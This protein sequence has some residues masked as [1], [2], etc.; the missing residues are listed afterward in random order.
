MQFPLCHHKTTTR[1][2]S[3]DA[4][5]PATRR[6][7]LLVDG[8]ARAMILPFG[9]FLVHR[10]V[11]QSDV[12]TRETWPG[13]A[14]YFAFAVSVYLVGRWLGTV[15][16][17]SS[18]AKLTRRVARLG[19]AALALHVVTYGAGLASVTWLIAIRGLSAMLAGMLCGI[20][21]H[22]A[23]PEDA[24]LQSD[25][26]SFS[27]ESSMQ[28]VRRRQGYVDI[29]S[30]TAKIY[31]VG[32]A[33]SILS[34]GLL[35]RK[36]T[37]DSTFQ[38]LTGAYQYSWSPLFL[39]AVAVVVEVALRFL[40][41]RA[42]RSIP[43]TPRTRMRT[44][45]RNEKL[46][47]VSEDDDEDETDPLALS[48]SHS[49]RRRGSYSTPGRTRMES[50]TSIDD[51]H[52]C[53]S[54]FSDMDDA[55][56]S[57]RSL[58]PPMD[59]D[60]VAL[61]QDGKCVYPN[62]QPAMVPAGDSIARIPANYAAFYNGNEDKARRAWENTQQWRLEKRVW[63]IHRTP[64]T[65]F[66]K[67]KEAYPH[68]VHGFSKAGYP[69][70]Y[71][72]PGKMN[73]KE[74]FRSGC[75]ISDMVHH[76]T[77]F[78]EFIAHRIC[79]R[80]DVR[81]AL[82]PNAPPHSSSSWGIMVVMD[83]AGAGISSLSGDVLKYLK[84]AGDINSGH[85]PQNMKRAFVINSPFWLA[86]A[87]SGIKGILPESV[88][89]DLLS[90]TKY[91]E[92][93]REYIDEDQIPP[94]YGG[95]SPYPLGQ[96]PFET[97]LREL[98]AEAEKFAEE[99]DEDPELAA[100]HSPP[101]LEFGSID[102]MRVVSPLPGSSSRLRTPDPKPLR[103]RIGSVERVGAAQRNRARTA[104]EEIS[105]KRKVV[106]G[107]EVDI[108]T[109]VSAIHFGWS[110]VQGAIELALPLWLVS[111][112]EFGGLGYSPSRSGVSF[113]C[114]L[115]VLMWVMRTRNSKLVAQIPSKEPLRALRI[116]AGSE[117]V[118]FSLLSTIVT[119]TKPEDRQTSVMIMTAVI[120]GLSCLA[121]AS[122]LGRSASKILHRIAAD[123]IARSPQSQSWYAKYYKSNRLLQDCESGQ[124]TTYLAIA[125]EA[126]GILCV[127]PF[128]SW[129][130]S[131]GREAPFD[132][133]AFLSVVSLF[134]FVLYVCS[135]SLYLN[136]AGEFAPN[137]KDS[138]ANM[139]LRRILS[140][141]G[142]IVAVSAGDMASLLEETNWRTSLRHRSAS[143][144]SYMMAASME[145]GMDKGR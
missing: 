100:I 101:I 11:Y 51:F 75:D 99:E 71:E 79:T 114:A 86:G 23:L 72:Q 85:Y 126:T 133:S 106:F 142:E 136:T 67:I 38:A 132:G 26:A 129:S 108:F 3:S 1:T 139:G 69:I 104:S 15:L 32:F 9:P 98:V 134:S 121:L 45:S 143:S 57:G 87:W 80:T 27:L 53:R 144:N 33:L 18:T 43:P 93:L 95:T 115:L 60:E 116:G 55:F 81:A 62:G 30:G 91:P 107:V 25:P 7:A 42:A 113:F 77:F 119:A 37:K 46:P 21:A 39:I 59:A 122:M 36:V 58:S 131:S 145:E 102:E 29:S 78:T 40:F 5:P 47:L 63:K 92:A 17:S 118:L 10:L 34:G 48:D 16:A 64:N 44:W 105:H 35:F 120:I 66:A 56:S 6:V 68:F 83:V 141:V 84:Q 82:G 54:V 50:Y 130:L 8:M 61:Y 97:E 24:A 22:I 14:Y 76:Y 70:V 74:L 31:L 52:D 65:W 28:A 13:V 135:F 112:F 73:L 127:A 49:F 2:M 138:C 124:F 94:E 89:V 137:P 128:M 41:A 20:T 109:I 88:Q 125:G 111:P 103:R 90:S 117:A 140:F 96:H 19:G 4:P 12:P 123:G 110:V